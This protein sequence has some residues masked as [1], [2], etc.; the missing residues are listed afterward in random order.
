[1]GCSH[2]SGGNAPLNLSICRRMLA[3]VRWQRHNPLLQIPQYYMSS[4]LSEHTCNPAPPSLAQNGFFETRGEGHSCAAVEGRAYI[5][6]WLTVTG[7]VCAGSAWVCWS[8]SV[9]G[10][11]LVAPMSCT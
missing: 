1:M 9:L 6:A 10:A 4:V 11:H 5:T 2:T 7:L 3:H 8:C